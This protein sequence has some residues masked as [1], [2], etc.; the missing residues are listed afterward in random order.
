VIAVIE[1]G[2]EPLLQIGGL[3]LRWQAIGVA[4]ALLLALA[5]AARQARPPLAIANLLVI[6]V[7]IVP[8]AIV[9]GRFVHAL[10]NLEFYLARS[11]SL[12][13]PGVG[14][15]SLLGAVLG[16]C[17]TGAY[18]ARRLGDDVARWADVAAPA[19]LIA[20]GLG[21][22]AQLLGGSGQGLP[23]DGP[24][25]VSFTGPGT[26]VSASPG[27]PSHPAQVYEGLWMLAGVVLIGLFARR[28]NL[29]RG[30][31]FGVALCWFLVGRLLIAFTWRDSAV[32]G[33]LNAEQ[34]VTA[35]VLLGIAVAV[36]RS[37]KGVSW[38][39][40]GTDDRGARS[41]AR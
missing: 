20:I 18:V 4:A 16:G 12:L 37:D 36:L 40:A 31:L 6:I 25:A 28:R 38:T 13:D 21:K 30:S 7:A 2:F 29:A 22:L 23:F 27:M 14:S 41:A 5:V 19:L 26:W 24:W 3:A 34:A 1:L 33:P 8:G 9:G 35:A 11:I 32:I 17:V 39:R 10:S 15:L